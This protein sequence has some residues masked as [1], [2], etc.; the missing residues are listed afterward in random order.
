MIFQKLLLA[1]QLVLTQQK[2]HYRVILLNQIGTTP[3]DEHCES[4]G[5]RGSLLCSQPGWLPQ[6]VRAIPVYFPQTPLLAGCRWPAPRD[7]A[8][9][10]APLPCCAQQWACQGWWS[11]Q[12]LMNGW[13]MDKVF[14]PLLHPGEHFWLPTCGPG[15]VACG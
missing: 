14:A 5:L 2:A 8:G 13:M 9:I 7:Q 6:L 10:S 1:D 15:K 3:T 4:F 12:R 11:N